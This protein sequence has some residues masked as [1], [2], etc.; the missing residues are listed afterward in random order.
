MERKTRQRDAIEKVFL[1]EGRPLST[2]EVLL[3]A[4][5]FL[6]TLSQATVY[7]ALKS[8]LEEKW[9][10]TVEVPG[11]PTFYEIDHHHHHHHFHCETCSK[12]FE[13]EGCT[14]VDALTPPGFTLHSHEIILWGICSGCQ[15]PK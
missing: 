12:I 13:V 8:L 9:L 15:S 10:T 2:L 5:E 7:R 14:A 1:R 3:N 6:P 11:L 4:Q